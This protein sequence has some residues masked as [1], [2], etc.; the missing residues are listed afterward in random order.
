MMGYRAEPAEFTAGD[1][2]LAMLR[3]CV[4]RLKPWLPWTDHGCG[5]RRRLLTPCLVG[6]IDGT[7]LAARIPR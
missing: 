1:Q 6:L 5:H 2:P 3:Q 7:S 4:F